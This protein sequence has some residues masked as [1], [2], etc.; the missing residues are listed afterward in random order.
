MTIQLIKTSS[1][2]NIMNQTMDVLKQMGFSDEFI[3][4]IQKADDVL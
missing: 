1:K 2:N 4:L 3:T